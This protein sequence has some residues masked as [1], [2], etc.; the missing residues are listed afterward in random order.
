MIRRLVHKNRRWRFDDTQERSID[1]YS[2]SSAEQ[3]AIW[4]G[5]D[6]LDDNGEVKSDFTAM[7]IDRDTALLLSRLLYFFYK[8]GYLPNETE[9]IRYLL[10]EED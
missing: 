3:E 1:V 6:K 7:H 4:V 9:F 10:H 8:Q 5:V 2:S